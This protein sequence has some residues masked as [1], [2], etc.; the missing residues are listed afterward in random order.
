VRYGT[1]VIKLLALGVRAVGLGRPFAYAN[2]Y[3]LEG[4][5]KA[6]EIMKREIAVDA[7]SIGVEDLQNVDSNLVSS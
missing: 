1:D 2:V 7:A 6:I 5:K 4:V 3:G